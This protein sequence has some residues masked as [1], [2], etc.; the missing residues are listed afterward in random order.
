MGAR[1]RYGPG[2]ATRAGNRR[3]FHGR[4]PT[5]GPPAV[6]H[7]DHKRR[8]TGGGGRPGGSLR[9]VR[10]SD[11]LAVQPRS[12][13]ERC[14]LPRASHEKDERDPMTVESRSPVVIES[15]EGRVL[16]SVSQLTAAVASSTLAAAV[17]D[18]T[19]AAGRVTV[20]V[21]N[22][23]GATE[24]AR[25]SIRHRRVGRRVRPVRRHRDHPGVQD[26]V[27]VVGER[28]DQVVRRP[29]EGQGRRAGRRHVQPVR[30]GGGLAAGRVGLPG[31]PGVGRGPRR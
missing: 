15:M 4:G 30:P 29:G 12:A 19:A 21:T 9:R 24:K 17:S 6:R 26:P 14:C 18:Q 16:F 23:S 28:A 8:P 11:I 3:R 7:E 1:S 22:D 20:S 25:V 13:A 27:A 10:R 2:R 5:G 31:R